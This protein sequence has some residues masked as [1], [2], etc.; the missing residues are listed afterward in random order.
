MLSRCGVMGRGQRIQGRPGPSFY[1][2]HAPFK[3]VFFACERKLFT[4]QKE[5]ENHMQLVES[6]REK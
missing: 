6:Y 4:D 1:S 5:I 2:R 3:L